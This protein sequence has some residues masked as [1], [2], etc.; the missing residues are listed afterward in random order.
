MALDIRHHSA[1]QW[2]FLVKIERYDGAG[3]SSTHLIH[4]S[5]IWRSHFPRVAAVCFYRR[6]AVL[7]RTLTVARN[8]KFLPAYVRLLKVLHFDR[9][10]VL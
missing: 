4:E 10:S 6:K 9:Y 8:S 1:D 7:L 2:Q 5:V 3:K